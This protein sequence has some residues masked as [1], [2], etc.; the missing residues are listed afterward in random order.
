MK[1]YNILGL[2]VA[3]A[4]SFATPCLAADKDAGEKPNNPLLVGFECASELKDS[5]GLLGRGTDFPAFLARDV[6]TEL[7]RQDTR[8]HLVSVECVGE[9]EI[10]AGSIP[11]V[12][13]GKEQNVLSSLSVTFPLNIK[14]KNGT[15]DITLEVDQNY[16]IENLDKPDQQKTTQNFIVKK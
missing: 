10:K 1:K 6:S 12:D 11:V 5:I 13:N 4:L 16:Y 15:T 9:P 8:S 14:L 7:K 2:V 3:S